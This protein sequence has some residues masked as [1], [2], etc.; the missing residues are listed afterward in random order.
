MPFY[1]S[2]QSALPS[3]KPIGT[4]T[5]KDR[6]GIATP[7]LDAVAEGF[8]LDDVLFRM[9]EPHEIARAMAFDPSYQTSV[10]DKRTKVKL[11]GN[12][13]TAPVAE[14]IMSALVEC[15]T[16]EELDRFVT[17]RELVTAA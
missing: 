3:S 4:L 17:D 13:V 15:I 9:L 1:G 5:T 10:K 16:G 11:F 7:D 2:A 12:A 6:Y 14:L 8:D